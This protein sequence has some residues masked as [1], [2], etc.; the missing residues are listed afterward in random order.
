MAVNLPN[1][2]WVEIFKHVDNRALLRFSR[3][4]KRWN[5][6]IFKYL[7]HRFQ[8]TLDPSKRMFPLPA[9]IGLVPGRNY[10]HLHLKST[11]L[12]V[13]MMQIIEQLAPHL[14]SLKLSLDSL[15][16]AALVKILTL[17][18]RLNELH[19]KGFTFKHDFDLDEMLHSSRKSKPA[20]SSLD[21]EYKK[22]GDFGR[23]LR[24]CILDVTKG[25]ISSASSSLVPVNITSLGLDITN[26]DIF[27]KVFLNSIRNVTKLDIAIRQ[28]TLN[29][30]QR[31]APQLKLLKMEVHESKAIGNVLQ[32]R[33][34]VL[35]VLLLKLH[36]TYKNNEF[37]DFLLGCQTLGTALLSL[38]MVD[39][40]DVF[41]TVAHGLPRVEKLQILSETVTSLGDLQAMERL[42]VLSLKGGYIIAKSCYQIGAVPTVEK[43]ECHDV[44]LSDQLSNVL[45]RFPNL[46]SLSLTMREL[47]YELNHFASYVPRLREFTITID[48]VNGD[49]IDLMSKLK[50]L[51]KIVI[52]AKIFAKS[53]FHFLR[54][55]IV[56]PKLK[57]LVINTDWELPVDVTSKIAAV[58]R[59][60]ALVLNGRWVRPAAVNVR[61]SIGGGAKRVKLDAASV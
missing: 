24:P 7:A 30:V 44:M 42:K 60:C 6:L 8:L 53:N 29:V 3:V 52:N 54:K 5:Q 23:E 17:C 25:D 19:I 12:Y 40:Q 9:S 55:V 18:T 36:S 11:K 2:I 10:T 4:C 38:P 48:R 28:P 46:H 31:L 41:P 33:L 20:V 43:F 51:E 59:S 57:R 50:R 26:S 34:P 15:D 27:E 16:L 21:L 37:K 1:E 22:L 49:A 45:K 58:N 35:D 14:E 47:I 61:R 56:L 39:Y 13:Q 32:L